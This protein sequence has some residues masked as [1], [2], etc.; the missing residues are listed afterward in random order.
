V[1]VPTDGGETISRHFGQAKYFMVFLLETNQVV[2][3]EMR[4][5]STHQ[6]ADNSHTDGVHPGQQMVE[7]LSDCQVLISGG[8]GTK[9]FNRAIA[10][11][12]QVFLTENTSILTAVQAYLAGTIDNNPT[13]MY[14]Y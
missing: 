13:L 4:E 5:K 8:M 1:V 11:G 12:L 6:H 14:S 7:S 3:Y 9:V 2:S 10:A